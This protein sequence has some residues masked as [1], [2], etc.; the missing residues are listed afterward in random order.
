MTIYVRVVTIGKKDTKHLF[1]HCNIYSTI[2]EDLINELR[3]INPN[4]NLNVAL[5]LYGS[6]QLSVNENLLV[7]QQVYS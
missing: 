7:F 5:L 1:F 3:N 6:N 4:V 2:R